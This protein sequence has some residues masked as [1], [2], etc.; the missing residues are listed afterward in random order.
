M[1]DSRVIESF[2]LI[3]ENFFLLTYLLTPWSRVL[4]E[5]LTCSQLVKKIPH[6][7]W[8]SKVHYRFYRSPPPVPILSQIKDALCGCDFVQYDVQTVSRAHITKGHVGDLR[9]RQGV[10]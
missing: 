2:C 7:V 5:T 8:H 3:I 6:I 10:W 1:S 9:Q 4:L